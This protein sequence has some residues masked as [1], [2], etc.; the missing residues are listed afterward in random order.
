MDSAGQL[1]ARALDCSIDSGAAWLALGI[2][3]APAIRQAGEFMEIQH[4]PLDG[5]SMDK[6]WKARGWTSRA[7]SSL[8]RE[9]RAQRLDRMGTR[10]K[11]MAAGEP[12][13]LGGIRRCRQH[14]CCYAGAWL[15]TSGLEFTG[16]ETAR[17]TST[18]AN[19]WREWMARAGFMEIRWRYAIS[20]RALV[21]RWRRRAECVTII[22]CKTDLVVT[23]V[24]SKLSWQTHL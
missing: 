9:P 14:R 21:Q 22:F 18:H 1:P 6:A 24:E 13:G 10:Q 8:M 15:R 5:D 19:Y 16:I 11:N 4:K 23:R 17:S 2:G 7:S 20:M 12:G 3:C